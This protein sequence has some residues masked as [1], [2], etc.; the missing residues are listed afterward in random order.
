MPQLSKYEQIIYNVLEKTRCLTTKQAQRLIEPFYEDY[1]SLVP[2]LLNELKF[3]TTMTWSSD[4]NYILFSPQEKVS[5]RMTDA[6][7]VMLRLLEKIDLET[8]EYIIKA[9]E[10]SQLCYMKNGTMYEVISI[11]DTSEIIYMVMLHKLIKSRMEEGD[12]P[13]IYCKY[14]VILRDESFLKML[15][16]VSFNYLPVVLQYPDRDY[17]A[18]PEISFLEPVEGTI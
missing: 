6:V 18:E 16:K 11:N 10:P 12:D 7:W 8:S 2:L 13:N 9:D 15:P 17:D 1:E 14:V 5:G 4:K 3:K